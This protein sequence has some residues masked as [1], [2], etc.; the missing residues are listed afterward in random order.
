LDS[1]E[2]NLKGLE[3]LGKNKNLILNHQGDVVDEVP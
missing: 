2:N 1:S 3:I